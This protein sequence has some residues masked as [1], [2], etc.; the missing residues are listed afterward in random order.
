[1]PNTNFNDND[2]FNLAQSM[3]EV[4]PDLLNVF[5]TETEKAIVNLSK[6][7][8]NQ[9]WT[10]I[11]D[12][13]HSLKSSCK[14]FGAIALSDIAYSIET[15]SPDSVSE[16]EMLLSQFADEYALVKEHMIQLQS[17]LI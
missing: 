9:E 7:F 3:D 5:Y 13:G 10:E 12:T 4:F 6:Y 16:I 8:Q 15:T 11:S 14:T 2:F 1:M 17:S